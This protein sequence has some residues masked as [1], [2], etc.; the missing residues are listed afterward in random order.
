MSDI[1]KFISDQLSVWPLAAANFRLVK[2]AEYKEFTVGGQKVKVQMNPC[3]IA[4]STAEIDAAAISAR[5][6]FLCPENRP[7]EQFHLKYEGKKGR[8]YNIQIN[9]YPIFRN[10]LVIARDCHLPQTIWHHFPDMLLFARSFPEY[11]VYY[12]GPVSGASAP[13]HLHFQACP[14]GVLP[15]EANVD[16]FLDNPGPAIA[17]VQDASLYKYEGYTRGIYV[18]KATTQKSMAKLA[19][20]LLECSPRREGEGEPRFNLYCW[21]NAGEFRTMVVLRSEFRS[22]H[23]WSKG[24]DHL[25]MSPGAAEMGAFFVA[26]KPEDFAKINEKL[27]TE[28][29]DEVSISEEQD[30]MVVW[31]L[32]RKQKFIDVGIMAAKEIRFEI[33]SDGAGPQRVSFCDGRIN[34][35]GALYDSLTFDAVTRSTLFAEPTFILYD[36]PIGIDFHWQQ[37]VTRRFAG[38][39]SFIV[40]DDCIRAVNR[41]GTEDY[42][43]SVI[44]SEMRSEAPLEFL[45]AHAIIARSWLANNLASHEGFDV[46][47]DDH[48]QRYQGLDGAGSSSVRDAIDQTWGQVLS[49]KGEVCD[50]RYSK[51]CG[52]RTEIFST[53]WEGGDKPYLASVDDP[54]CG[55]AKP[56]LLRRVLNDYDLPTTDYFEW[57][58]RYSRAE[59]SDLVARR[60]GIDFGKIKALEPVE[61]GPSG[62]IKTLR[63]VGSKRSLVIGRELAVRHALSESHLK[64]SAFTVS[65]EGDECVLRG[66]GWGHGVGLCQIGAAV[67]ASEGRSCAEILSHYYPGSEIVSADD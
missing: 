27:L 61:T 34:Y 60:T 5:K 64:S 6:C 43:L 48:C 13:D 14:R 54:W 50:T 24:A 58:V 4:S 25:T 9:P 38:R 66:R 55:K 8:S 59:L 23:Y 7:K 35:G 26:P 3:R 36:V 62:R 37:K 53:C 51:C 31:R 10:H 15:L 49:Y 18:M 30:R 21:Y 39:L 29:I 63:I 56:E 22:H 20:R 12:N 19:Y 32:T 46:C 52:G 65:W 33:I 45:K 47:A 40:E 44:S 57:E 28:M 41:I 17:G 67:M 42:L 1:N 16:A 2:S 11:T